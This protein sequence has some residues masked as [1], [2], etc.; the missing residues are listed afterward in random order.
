MKIYQDR[1]IITRYNINENNERVKGLNIAYNLTNRRIYKGVFEKI[2][3]CE[4]RYPCN[5]LACAMCVNRFQK[6][7][8][9]KYVNH[10]NNDY[11]FVTLIY[12]RDKI[13]INKFSKFNPVKLKDKLRK[14]LKVIGFNK[15]ILGSLEIDLHLYATKEESYY[16]PHFHL[17]MP[18]EKEK[19]NELRSYMKSNY[20]LQGRIGVK[21]R[22][23]LVKKIDNLEGVIRY[24]TKFMWCEIP[25]YLDK[26]GKLKHGSKRRIS[27][28][29][30]F[31]DSLVKLD[32]L[33]VSD[34]IFKCNF[35]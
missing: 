1:K 15:P 29:R 24:I 34:M 10:L 26:K 16:L 25:W 6:E 19:L 22:P 30:L 21:N 7:I 28:N 11:V 31:A 32:N 18:N 8:I 14:K 3:N 5:S 9:G 13:P 33:K 20:N 35:Q 2:N 12:Y 17:I 23:M 27:N 4:R